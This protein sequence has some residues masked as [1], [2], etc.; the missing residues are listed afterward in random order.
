MVGIPWSKPCLRITFRVTQTIVTTI[1]AAKRPNIINRAASRDKIMVR[2]RGL[3]GAEGYHCPVERPAGQGA[4]QQQLWNVCVVAD[5][6]PEDK[7]L[8]HCPR[9]RTSG[10]G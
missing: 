2:L 4:I 1:I 8:D 10:S 7:A 3:H 6:V 9:P 5:D